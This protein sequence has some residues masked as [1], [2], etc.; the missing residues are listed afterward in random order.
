[1]NVISTYYKEETEGQARAEVILEGDTYSINFYD[2]RG[3]F[4][5]QE[6][7]VGKSLRYV[8]DTAENWTLGI[9]VLNG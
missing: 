4:F 9:K 3:E 7:Y 1:M 6:S 2:A 5:M 8:E